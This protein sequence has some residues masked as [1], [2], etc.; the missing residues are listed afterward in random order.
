M[1]KKVQCPTPEEQTERLA[2]AFL[3]LH[4]V[5]E[6]LAFFSD[7]FTVK[8]IEELS[9]RLEVARLLRLGV[10]YVD[11]AAQTGASTAT[12]SRVSKCLSGD[13]GGY[14]M[15]FS[16]FEDDALV[17]SENIIRTDLLSDH[18]TTIIKELVSCLKAK[19]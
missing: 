3:S 12:I 8:E 17:E 16:R 10:N 6:C 13:K 11:I 18:E 14:R 1:A 19:K 9:S 2:K 15:V 5:D 4:D 7:L